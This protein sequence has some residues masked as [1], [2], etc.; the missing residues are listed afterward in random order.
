M[1]K[2]ILLA[3]IIVLS[4]CGINAGGIDFWPERN[5]FVENLQTL[6]VA[7]YDNSM[8]LVKTELI[9]E[10]NFPE[11][12]VLT[13]AVGYSIVDD[14]TYR[15]VYYAREAV[16]ALEDGGLTSYTAPIAYKKSQQFDLIGE[17]VI[18]G[19]QFALV[20]TSEKDFVVL[21]NSEG[22]V[23]NKIGQMRGDRFL[24]L[25]TEYMVYPKGFAFEAVTLTKSEQTKPIKGFD[26]KYGGLKSGYVTLI[27]YK[28]S[29]P[30]TEGLY[31][32]GEFEVLSYPNRSGP[33][34]VKGVKLKIIDAKTDSL[35]YMILPD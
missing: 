25:D 26:I 33:I 35:D 14:K 29:E 24:L 10:R 4:A 6:P 20:P 16:R 30:S 15:K 2:F 11:N 21:I 23:Y 8:Q 9:T 19:E 32:K 13:A 27:Y 3:G 12:R 31:D 1:K 34:D 28:Y 5:K 7:F 18:D 17:V 22:K